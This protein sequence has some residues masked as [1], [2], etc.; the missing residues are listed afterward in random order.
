M[1][2]RL[3]CALLTFVMVISLVPATVLTASAAGYA[4]SESAITVLKQWE[5]Y[6]KTCNV[7]GITGYGTF[8]TEDGAHGGHNITEKQAD[9]A[10]RAKLKE[11][12]K[13]VNTF[14][15]NS[16]VALTQSK[17]DALVLFSFENGTAWTTGTGDFRNAVVS[18]V[19]GSK[20]LNAI[21]WWDSDTGDDNRRMVEANMYLNGTYSTAV[22]SN[23]IRVEYNANGGNLSGAKYR[24]YDTTENPKADAVPTRD[25]FT[26]MG[27]YN[28]SGKQVT[29]LSKN[30]TLYA[31]WQG[32]DVDPN[33]GVSV[34]YSR[35]FANQTALYDTPSGDK[36]DYTVKGNVTID[37]EYIDAKNVRWGRVSHTQK[38][39]EKGV[40]KG[41]DVTFPTTMTINKKSVTQYAW[42]NLGKASDSSSSSSSGTSY[43]MDVTVTVTNSYLR[44]RA[45]DSIFSRELRRA[46]QG[47]QLRIVNTS[48]ADGFLWGQIAD[49]NGDGVCEGWVALMYTN[50]ESVKGQGGKSPESYNVIGTATVIKP[51]NG[52]VN[53]RNGAGLNKQIV[54]AL[55]YQTKADLY[56]IQY[57][58]GMRWGR[59]D[60]GWFSLSYADVSG[61]DVD[62]YVNDA[63]V[64]AYAFTGEIL[65]TWDIHVAPRDD[66]QLVKV[67]TTFK[68]EN[69][70]ITHL[71]ADDAG[72]TWGKITEGWVKVSNATGGKENV[73]LDPAR[74][75]TVEAG[76]T[77]RET[78]GN[79]ATRVT[80]LTK[81]VEFIVN[82]ND[83]HQVVVFNDTIWGYADKY[84]ESTKSYS[85]W[86]NL[87]TAHVSRTDPASAEK[88]DNSNKTS[89]LMA[90]VVGTDNANVR[91][92]NAATYG[93]I[94][95]LSRGVT[96]AVWEEEDG[97]YKV[98]SNRNGKY[99]YE[100]DGWVSGQYLNV[101]KSSEST[102]SNGGSGSTGSS[103]ST[104]ETGMGIIANTY[105][106]VNVRTGAGT[107]YAAKGKILAGSSVEILEVKT[108]GS[109][110]WGRVTQGWI[111]MD[112]VTMISNYPVN[113]SGSNTNTGSNT[114]GGSSNTIASSDVILT[115]M[116]KEN[117]SVFKTPNQDDEV[118]RT[119]TAGVSN[120]TIHELLTVEEEETT[121]E[122]DGKTTITKVV[123]HWAR[124]NDGY[125]F[126]P[127]KN[128]TLDTQNEVTYTVTGVKGDDALTV[129]T[130][131]GTGDAGKLY[132]YDTV[133]VTQMKIVENAVW[134][135]VEGHDKKD[136]EI[137]GW[138]KFSN[139]TQG[140]VTKPVEN[141]NTGNGG[142][143][144]TGNGN[145]NLNL[146]SSGNTGNQGSNGFVSNSGGYRYTGKVIRT[147]SVNVRAL[148]SQTASL[149]TTMKGGDAL[150]VYET[151]ISEGMAW[152]RC[153]AGWVYLYYVDLQ[154]CNNAVDAKVVYNE[155]TIIYTDSNCSE[156][157]GTYSRMSVVDIYEQVGD[158]CRTD[159]GWVHIDNLG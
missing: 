122:G 85:G 52:Y 74:Y 18:G 141:T 22:P 119:L 118:V 81:G 120:V 150:V 42:L 66:A 153:D 148:P 124:I 25:H 51:V 63:N 33:V 142:N 103:G 1:K 143:T 80:N 2:K 49:S 71:T 58:N 106:G 83:S 113:G 53:L 108:V 157:A 101:F 8:C 36:I 100:G 104:V 67:K 29:S 136:N 13:A 110:K 72:N 92:Y 130:T 16:G 30:I 19:K 14:A 65:T 140:V 41:E 126:N 117:V 146:G 68:T 121:T 77:V 138:V 152:G 90:T 155:N 87:T 131:P 55:P 86:V 48:Q 43:S 39:Y 96:V 70:T 93:K 24:Y 111:C 97:W 11:L 154:P 105:T 116:A 4:T 115:G 6:S 64:L 134:V 28:E 61:I 112:Y 79:D 7:Y 107:G 98:D 46:S 159:Q 3:L 60:G 123:K 158:M 44:V 139:L 12:D 99:D 47:E 114:S 78:P 17:H 102:G 128:I 56:E 50:Y 132:Q 88:D 26:F 149:T 127:E 156:V 37:K 151:T 144:N 109:S 31:N 38:F 129:N 9:A 21:C 54:G 94:G 133:T 73:D 57:V 137:T 40:K 34:S 45:E 69:R 75:F 89:D 76:V 147:G 135:L 59:T 125:V 91:E 35:E 84:G 32:F 20:F 95:T 62:D 23:F 27:W 82:S 15:S 145:G 5:G 10:L